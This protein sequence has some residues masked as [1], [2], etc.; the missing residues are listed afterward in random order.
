MAFEEEGATLSFLRQSS[1]GVEGVRC[2]PNSERK[3]ESPWSCCVR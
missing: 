3:R 2:L 1:V